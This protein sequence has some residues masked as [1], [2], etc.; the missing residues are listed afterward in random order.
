[1]ILLKWGKNYSTRKN[2]INIVMYLCWKPIH[3]KES[4]KKKKKLL[5]LSLVFMPSGWLTGLY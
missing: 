2:Y 4:E 3:K 5:G 1:M